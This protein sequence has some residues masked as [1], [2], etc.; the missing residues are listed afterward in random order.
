MPSDI[1]AKELMKEL[2][3]FVPYPTLVLFS[4][5]ALTTIAMA[6]KKGTGKYACSESESRQ[7]MHCG[8]YLWISLGSL[9]RG[10]QAHRQF[11]FGDSQHYEAKEQRALL[12][13]AGHFGG[14]EVHPE[15][16]RVCDRLR[17]GFAVRAAG[18][19]HRRIESRCIGRREGTRLLQIFDWSLRLRQYLRNV[20]F[21]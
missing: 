7:L 12:C 18:Y 17:A 21:K 6:D 16:H 4:I 5:V 20:W 1:S 19:D 8:E 9:Y 2:C 13:K 10:R 14:V 11:G 15:E 3:R